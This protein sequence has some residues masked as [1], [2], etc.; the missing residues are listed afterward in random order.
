MALNVLPSA[1]ASDHPCKPPRNGWPGAAMLKLLMRMN[2][3]GLAANKPTNTSVPSPT[4]ASLPED[5]EIQP[6]ML[7]QTSVHSPPGTLERGTEPCCCLH[8][9]GLTSR[10]CH[11]NS[12]VCLN[13]ANRHRSQ[14]SESCLKQITC[15]HIRGG[16]KSPRHND[17][18]GA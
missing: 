1:N 3:I 18:S 6:V 12:S 15:A 9:G 10:P 8:F 7:R 13:E 16:A 5:L 14:A 2:A 17:L 11:L 4:A